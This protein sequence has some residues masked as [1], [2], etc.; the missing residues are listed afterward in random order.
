MTVLPLWV[1]ARACVFFSISEPA[2]IVFYYT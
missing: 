1:R 2:V